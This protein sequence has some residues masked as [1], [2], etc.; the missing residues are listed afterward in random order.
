[1]D[2]KVNGTKNGICLIFKLMI[3]IIQEIKISITIDK[4]LLTI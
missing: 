4:S 2:N 3:N 1:M